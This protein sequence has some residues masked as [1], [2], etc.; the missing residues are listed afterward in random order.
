MQHHSWSLWEVEF[1]LPW[2]RDI[3]LALLEQHMKEL[4]EERK[5]QERSY[6]R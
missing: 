3:Y 4:E 6:G 2:E 5:K 1:M